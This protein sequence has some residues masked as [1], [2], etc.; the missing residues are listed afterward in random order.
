MY[1]TEKRIDIRARSGE[2]AMRE[3]VRS[4]LLDASWASDKSASSRRISS[5]WCSLM[6]FYKTRSSSKEPNQKIN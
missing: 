1:Y 2:Q 5:S 4:P 6:A 3:R